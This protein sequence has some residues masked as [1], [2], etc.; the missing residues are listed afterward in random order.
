MKFITKKSLS[1][2][3]FLRGASA[4]I[5]LPLLDAMMPAYAR[6]SKLPKR[7]TFVYLPN[8][9]SMNFHGTNYWK[10]KQIG[11]RVPLSPILKPLEKHR[12]RV[13]VFSGLVQRP[14]FPAADGANGDHTRATATWL[15]GVHPKRT[16]GADVRDGISADQIAARTIGKGLVLSSLELGIDLNFL[17]GQCENGYACTYLNTVAWETPTS[18]LPA[19]NN[20]RI[21]FERLF[22]N[23]GTSEQRKARAKQNRSILDSVSEDFGR[24]SRTLGPSDQTQLKGYLESVRDVERR[25]QA[26]ENLRPTRDGGPLLQRPHGIPVRF[27]KHMGLMFELQRLAF[28]SD[29]TRVVTFMTGRELNFRSHPEIGINEGHHA[30]SHHKNDPVKMAELAKLNTYFT[31]LFVDHLDRLKETSEAGGTLLDNT[32]FLY[33]AALS[34][35]NIHSHKDVPLSVVGGDPAWHEGGRHLAFEGKP[36]TN[37]LLTLLDRVGV[38]AESLGDSTGVLDV[39]PLVS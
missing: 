7:L 16:E 13:S 20:P 9:V 26:I 18:P 4:T 10:P 34:D 5:G 12:E 33:G 29:M 30:L 25:I 11:R 24:L 3:T 19:E 38:H 28:Q 17:S 22:G 15:T 27:D 23:G 2:R 1:R 37:L 36:M 39:E 14:A 32:V 21:V 8:G 35:P 6:T 31:Q